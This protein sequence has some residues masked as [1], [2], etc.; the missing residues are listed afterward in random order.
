MQP[1]NTTL[2]LIAF[3]AVFIVISLLALIGK[4]KNWYWQSPRR[5]YPYLPLGFL[6]LLAT[7]DD[8][9]Q[10]LFSGSEWVVTAI[11]AIFMAV[12]I[13]FAIAPPK[14]IKP[15]WVRIIEEHPSNVY[16]ELA[17]QAKNDESWRKNV[18]DEQSLRLWI[19]QARKRPAKK[20]A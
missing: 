14:A 9:L 1:I 6:F 3:A 8:Q 2:L 15:K 17:R 10:E 18:R 11:Y 13:W 7:F 19:E 12:V 4:W 5:V 16:D 20:K